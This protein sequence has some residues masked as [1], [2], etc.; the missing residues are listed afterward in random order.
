MTKIQ[1]QLNPESFIEMAANKGLFHYRCIDCDIP[2]PRLYMVCPGVLN[3]WHCRMAGLLITREQKTELL[4][5]RLP[6]TFVTK[7]L[8]GAVR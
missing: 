6:H 4:E 1:K 2:V 7:P 5:K 8:H 3:N